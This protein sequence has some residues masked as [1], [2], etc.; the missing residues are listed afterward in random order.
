[1]NKPLLTPFS[2]MLNKKLGWLFVMLTVLGFQE[3][4]SQAFPPCGTPSPLK[5]VQQFACTAETDTLLINPF[6]GANNY[7]LSVSPPGGISVTNLT[8]GYPGFKVDYGTVPGNYLLIFSVNS[9]CADTFNVHVTGRFAPQINC[10]D[11]VHF[12]LDEH[13]KGTVYP[14]L[15]L[16]GIYDSLDYTVTIKDV[17]TGLPIP[18]SPH[19]NSTHLGKYYIVE[20]NHRCS[21][22]LCWGILLVE[23]KKDPNI[24]CKTYTVNCNADLSPE[25]VGFPMP[26][27]APNPN[28]IGPFRYR[29]FSSLVDNCSSTILTYSDRI[30]HADCPPSVTYID[31]VFRDWTAVDGYGNDVTCTDTILI[32]VGNINSVVC[33]PNYDGIAH[34]TLN[35]SDNYKRDLAGNPHPDVTGYPT[36]V[37]C[38]NLDFTYQDIKIRVCEGTYKILRE[39]II[40]DWCT[41][42]Q[43]SCIQIIKVVDD[44]GPVITCPSNITVST[45]ANSC[46]GEAVLGL[47]KVLAECSSVSWVVMVKRG[48]DPN[49]PPSSIDASTAGV[50][51]LSNDQYKIVN[52]PVG[53]S[54]VLF[55]GSDACGNTDTCATEVFVIEKTRPIAVCDLETVVTLTDD[56][57]AK[58]YAI[59]FDDGSH[60]NCELG[61]FKVR[62]MDPGACPD[63]IKDDNEFGD[64]VEFCCSDIPNNP[65]LVVFQ[66]SDKAGNT[67]ECMVRVTVQD[68]KPPVVTCLPDITVSCEFDRSNLAVFGTYR[69]AEFDRNIINLYD[70]TNN[71][72]SQPHYWGKDGLVI[73]DC[74]LHIDSSISYVLNNCGLGNIVRRYEFYD[75]F[76]S[77]RVCEQNITVKDFTLFNGKLSITW[78]S[79]IEIDGCHAGV[80]PEL[81]GKPQWPS[82]I[83]CSNIIATYDDQVF[84]VV[85]NVCFKILRTWTVVDWCL[86]N[87]TTGVGRWTYIQVIKVKNSI[88]PTFTSS[89]SNV[90][91]DGTSIDCNGF[92]TLVAEAVDDCNPAQLIYTYDIDLENNG[93]K[94]LS[95]TGNNASGI[96]P[97][98]THRILW[99]VTDQCGNSSTCSYLFTI[100]DRKQPTPVCQTGI[101]TVIMPT[102][103]Q[104]TIWASDLNF[105]SRDNCTPSNLLRYSFSSN[106]NNASRTYTCSQ[107]PNGISQKFEVRVYVTDEAGNQDYCDTKVIIQDGLG[108]ACPDNLGGG[109]TGNLAGAIFNEAHSNVENAM[110]TLNGNMPNMPKYQITALDGQYTFLNLPLNE[111]YILT[112]TKDDEPLNG[113]STQDIVLIQKH[114][115]GL[116]TLSSPYKVI[117]ADV[118]NSQSITAK[119]VSDLRRLILGITAQFPDNKSWKFINGKQTFANPVQPWPFDEINQVDKLNENILDN[120]FVA[121]K[122]GD[123]S[124][125]ARTNN[126]QNPANRSA[127]QSSIRIDNMEYKTNEMIRIPVK[128]TYE[129]ILTGMQIAF[130][131]DN[132]SLTLADIESGA[133]KIT[134]SNYL[135]ESAATST[136]RISW[137]QISGVQ[138]DQPLFYLVFTSTR[139]GVLSNS[140]VLSSEIRPEA[141]TSNADPIEL[142]ISYGKEGEM[143]QGFYLYQNQPN[144]FNNTTK[145][146]FNLPRDG[147]VTLSILDV[148]G[149]VLHKSTRDGKSGLNSIEISKEGLFRS[150]VLYYQIEMGEHKAVRKMLLIE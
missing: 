108:N 79:H 51:K 115:L 102:N 124:G 129:G 12:S 48:A 136:V 28:K 104:V 141:Y 11:T 78:P 87:S 39:W 49:V 116:Q 20:V 15:V 109:T 32:R 83:N 59:T 63:P 4:Y 50:I 55:I 61:G 113:V 25:S 64:Y 127:I 26:A 140:L 122:M 94:D 86:Y 121:V 27:G 81:T 23:D 57:S 90:I 107:I 89:C 148:D 74:N 92:A 13:C 22:N 75:D 106:P 53:L 34:S 2:W 36:F 67:N 111:N 45:L 96:Y 24:V 91:F 17:V 126:L 147:Q 118:N 117:A 76:N 103:G 137:D 35:C 125:N 65:I 18:T 40:A 123:V 133:V 6:I 60:D 46:E 68:K 42:T 85:E 37:S 33:P 134:D 38:R 149:K 7:Q 105:G 44:R 95:G 54:W 110:V 66:V 84:N 9:T 135:V 56:G 62:R 10:N 97:I 30:S 98:G 119:D 14:N 71:S 93:S 8:P 58:V 21:G 139:N 132:N 70:S 72:I 88:S 138:T 1:M 41:G 5:G 120:H 43:T 77:K 114:I 142:E 99:T 145:I 47:P 31:T 19:L 150:G 16:E 73:E 130:A 29:S 128:L 3:L 101:I 112:A 69:R 131:Y 143:N 80:S 82:N 144:P 146:S 100:V 52:L